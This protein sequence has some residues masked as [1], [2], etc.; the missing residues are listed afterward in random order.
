MLSQLAGSFLLQFAF[1]L[2]LDIAVLEMEMYIGGT[3]I[4]RD[5]LGVN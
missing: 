2:I 5:K 3:I 4:Q 1:L